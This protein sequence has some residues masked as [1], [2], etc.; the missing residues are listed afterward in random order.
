MSLTIRNVEID[1]RGG[2]DV[3]IDGGKIVAIGAKLSRDGDDIDGRGGALIP[4]LCDHHIHLFALAARQDSVVLDGVTNAQAFADRIK[5][6]LT[7]RPAG[8]WL[9]VLGYHETIAGE[10][11]RHELDAFAP[12]HKV[13]VQHQTGSLWI[14]NSLALDALGN[15]T[16]TNFDRDAGRIWRGDVWLRERIGAEIPPFTP[17]GR[18]LASYGITSVTD[19]SVTTDANAATILADAVRARDLPVH[20]TLMSGG[21]LI[22]P[23]DGAFAVGP[24]K[25][26]LDDHGLPPLDDFITWITR[27]RAWRRPVAVHC[28][29]ASEL[30]LALAAFEA[31]GARL[32]DRIEHGGV[33]PESAIAQIEHL[34]LTVVTQSAFIRERGDRYA[35]QI[36]PSEHDDLYRCASLVRAGIPV[37]GSSDAPYASADPWLGIATAIDRRSAGGVTLGAGEAL[38]S[39]AALNLYLGDPSNPGG[40]PR[41]IKV[42]VRADL[43]LLDAPLTHVLAEPDARHVR[44][45]F[46]DG[47]ATHVAT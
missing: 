32:G 28:V 22:A 36:A 35:M 24:V 43:C 12:R 39:L 40:P 16:P 13:R 5:T 33:I 15:D 45:T 3:R 44:A 1:G 10:L 27:A 31:A 17:I 26:L 47:A 6:A 9:R 41:D 34:R 19:A 7:Q 11:T 2:L 18:V 37:A 23:G 38:S 25:I 42:G 20:L 29:T 14:L 46:V 30:A 8:A 21:A 4:G